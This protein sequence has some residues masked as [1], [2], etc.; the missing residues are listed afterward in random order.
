ML[1]RK[2]RKASNVW[3]RLGR[4]MIE[5]GEA[6]GTRD[7]E[8]MVV[9]IQIVPEGSFDEYGDR[10]V[11][12]FT[13]SEIAEMVETGK[14]K[15]LLSNPEEGI[16]GIVL[17]QI[18]VGDGMHQVSITELKQIL[19]EA[20]GKVLS[21]PSPL[22]A[23]DR[24]RMRAQK[25]PEVK[26]VVV[27]G[28]AGPPPEEQHAVETSVGADEPAEARSAGFTNDGAGAIAQ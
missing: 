19:T 8:R 11:T 4:P 26:I 9:S 17:A 10:K 2:K 23:K 28:Q 20:G 14:G 7:Q 15:I 5:S 18:S 24:E 21:T 13:L 12:G 1:E 6:A 25:D 27:P 3:Y 16:E 22:D